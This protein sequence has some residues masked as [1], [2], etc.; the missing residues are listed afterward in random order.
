MPAAFI[1]NGF[2]IALRTNG[3][4]CHLILLPLFGRKGTKSFKM[5]IKAW[6]RSSS[7]IPSKTYSK[8]V[9]IGDNRTVARPFPEV[10][11]S[12]PPQPSNDGPCLCS[13]SWRFSYRSESVRIRR[14]NGSGRLFRGPASSI[15]RLDLDDRGSEIVANPERGWVRRVVDIHPPDVRG[16]R[17]KVLHHL[18]GSGVQTYHVIV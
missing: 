9:S 16:L 18:A 5:E 3:S 13:Q 10:I 7:T 8:V 11:G 1:T 2:P 17:Q 14:P 15:E 4:P 12:E 6:Q